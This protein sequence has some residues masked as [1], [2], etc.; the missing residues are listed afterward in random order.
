MISTV[1]PQ[2]R[3]GHKTASRGF[4]GYKGH[5]AID[6]DSKIITATEVTAGN[7]GDASAAEALLKDVLPPDAADAPCPAPAR[8]EVFGDASYG[9]AELV[10]KVEAADVEANMKVQSP[11]PPRV[12]M[13]S[14]HDF[15]VD[16]QAGTVTCPRGLRVVLRTSRDGS[17][18]AEFG[19]HCDD[20]PMRPKCT[21][22]K[23]G[24]SVRLHPK[25]AVLDRARTRQRDPAWRARYR[26]TRPKVERKIAHLM[27]R[28]HGGR[29]AR[30]RGRLRVGYDFALLAAAVN[31]AR[32]AVLGVRVE[33]ANP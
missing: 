21:A 15:A 6:P 7:V 5:I 13:F 30:M 10:E 31:I 18:V 27:R 33:R 22:S 19:P 16:T 12:G 9:T 8:A 2:A 4:D 25:H 23:E 20:C 17:K 11:S 28:K 32:L 26:A 14:Q 29:R 3:H 1:D 24:R